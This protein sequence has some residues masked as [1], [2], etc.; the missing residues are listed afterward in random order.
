VGGARALPRDRRHL[1]RMTD[2]GRPAHEQALAARD[3]IEDEVLGPLDADER[4]QLHDLLARAL[5]DRQ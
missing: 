1:V 4:Q 5:G 2:A 3:G